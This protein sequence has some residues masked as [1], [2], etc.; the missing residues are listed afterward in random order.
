VK[1]IAAVKVTVVAQIV[2]ATVLA[3][4]AQAAIVPREVLADSGLAVL[5]AVV[6]EAERVH[7]V[8]QIV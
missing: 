5:E 3:E 7:R 8:N 2:A 1:A 4:T 6:L